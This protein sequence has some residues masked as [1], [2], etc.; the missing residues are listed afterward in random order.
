MSE[1]DQRECPYRVLLVDDQPIVGEALGHWLGEGGGFELRHCLDGERALEVAQAWAPDVILQDLQLP[2]IDGIEL[3]TAYASDERLAHTP[4][5]MLSAEDGVAVRR[6]AFKAGADDYLIKLPD[7]FELVARLRYHA[8]AQRTRLQR[9]ALLAEISLPRVFEAS[10][11]LARI[12]AD[13]HWRERPIGLLAVRLEA[14]A[15]ARWQ[16]LRALSR[17]IFRLLA[18][19]TAASCHDLL[20]GPGRMS[21]LVLVPGTTPGMLALLSERCKRDL[22]LCAVLARLGIRL[23][24]ASS[25]RRCTTD[26][27]IDEMVRDLHDGSLAAFTVP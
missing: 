22:L 7:P 17:R 5:V 18:E 1:R 24:I 27:C 13:P 12:K 4:I 20:I 23:E 10:G 19:N 14:R 8:K 9:D 26:A 16:P 15:D 21:M 2:G 11:A 25:S 3:V 6:A